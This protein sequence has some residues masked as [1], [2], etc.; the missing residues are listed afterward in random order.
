MANDVKPT[1]AITG[2]VAGE[3]DSI[4]KKKKVPEWIIIV[5]ANVLT[6][7]GTIVLDQYMAGKLP[8]EAWGV[9]LITLITGVVRMFCKTSQDKAIIATS[10]PS[11]AVSTD[12]PTSDD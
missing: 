7:V 2:V 3:I 1:D 6:L 11:A 5:V 9:T 8:M 12:V 10:Q 4:L